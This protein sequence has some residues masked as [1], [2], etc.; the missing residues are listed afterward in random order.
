MNPANGGWLIAVTLVAAMLLGVVHLPETWPGWIGWLRPNW[1]ILV[2]FFWVIEVPRRVGLIAM[3]ITGLFVDVLYADPI[4]LNGLILA[5]VSYVGWRFFERL[6]MYSV[7]QQCGI[8]F[9]LVL[10][11]ELLSVIVLGLGSER[12]WSW[13]VVT[14]AVVTTLVWPLMF[15]MLLRLR[16]GARVE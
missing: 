9:L 11:A 1:L 15:L 6:R 10:G 5:S 13:H 2:L 12:Q 8:L 14:S 3:W 7:L 4:G 16:T